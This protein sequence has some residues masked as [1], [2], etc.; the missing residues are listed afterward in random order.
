MSAS[1][2]VSA[3]QPVAASTARPVD[4]G[5]LARHAGRLTQRPPPWLHDEVARRMAER[6]A[7]L[8]S[9]PQ[10]IVD[11]GAHAGVGSTALRQAC[12]QARCTTVGVLPGWPHPGAAA[13]APPASTSSAAAAGWWSWRR[14]FAAGDAARAPKPTID[15]RALPEGQADLLWSNMVLHH[16][17]DPQAAFARW[18]QL[19]AVDG[20]LMFSTLGPGTLESLRAVYRAAGWGPAHAPFVDMHDLGDMLVHAG[21]AG[22]VMDQEVIRLTWATPREALGELQQ[23][24]GNAD[25]ARFSGLRTPRW[26]HALEAAL[27]PAQAGAAQRVVLEFEVVY[28]HAVRPPP[29]ARVAAETTVPLAELRGMLQRP[30]PRSDGPTR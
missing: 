6:L 13:S 10:R 27:Q 22:P 18:R 25:P 16:L 23:L 17:A 24:G 19:L 2:G 11:W 21:F 15:E 9:A 29:R 30:G 26:R 8:R 5:A 14:W 20:I 3:R 12:P 7:V 28:G 4:A 1:P